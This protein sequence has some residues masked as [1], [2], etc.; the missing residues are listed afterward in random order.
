MK[1]IWMGLA[2]LTLIASA[3]AI[4]PKQHQG[5]VYEY[6]YSYIG[7]GTELDLLGMRYYQAGKYGDAVMLHYEACMLGDPYGCNHAGYM[8]DQGKGVMQ[9]YRIARK[10]FELACKYGNAIGCSNLGVIYEEGEEVEQ[11]DEKAQYYYQKSCDMGSSLG[12]ENLELLKRYLL[13]VK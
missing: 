7:P 12:C 4:M 8:Y 1:K 5:C 11:S 2:L 13:L 3:G 9:S 10:Y 6:T